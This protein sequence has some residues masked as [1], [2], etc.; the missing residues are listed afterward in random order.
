MSKQLALEPKIVT[1]EKEYVIG[2]GG[3]F[4]EE[5]MEKIKALWDKFLKREDEIKNVKGAYSLGVCM[6][7]HPQIEKHDG[8]SFIYIAGSPVSSLSEVPPGM[9][10]CEIPASRYAVFTHKGSLNKLPETMKYIFGTW[11]EKGGY[12][13]KNAPD[14]EL[15]DERFDPVSD[16]SEFDIYVPIV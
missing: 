13:K 6:M 9:V 15:Y 3:G 16:N 5:P 8:D 7:E 10:T 4:P 14:F 11:V 1:R 2:L 12:E